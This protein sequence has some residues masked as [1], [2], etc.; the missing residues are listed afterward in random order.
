MQP[1]TGRNIR[2]IP[3]VLGGLLLAG[4][5]GLQSGDAVTGVPTPSSAQPAP[6]AAW[7]TFTSDRYAYSI[8]HPA[9]WRAVEQVGSPSLA[10]MEIGE[11][12]TDVFGPPDHFRYA[13][14]D[15]VVVL[16]AH[17][18]L[19][20]ETLADFSDRVSEEAACGGG[21]FAHEEAQLDGEP[22]ESRRF[23][24]SIW[25]W[26][27]ITALHGGRGYVVWFVTTTGE[28]SVARPINQQFLDS[29]RFTD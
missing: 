7:V 20:G 3:V 28:S 16:S 23:E 4:C 14:D 8:G 22:A 6:S 25:E 17:E 29:F 11:S 26:R 2:R 10:G 18:L 5:V 24:C 1:V 15:G 19:D 13:S 12:G 9:D 21:S 27:Q